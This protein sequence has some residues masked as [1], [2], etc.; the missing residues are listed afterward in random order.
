MRKADLRI[1]R[2]REVVEKLQ[3]GEEVD[4]ERVLGTGDE[5]EEREW[6]EALKEI[7]RED[8]QWQE[9]RKKWQEEHDRLEAEKQDA[10]PTSQEQVKIETTPD[11]PATLPRP[12]PSQ[13]GFY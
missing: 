11:L 6:E 1:G 13:P 7:E 3:R 10:K 2:L 9:G 12:P 4:V 8:N 5:D